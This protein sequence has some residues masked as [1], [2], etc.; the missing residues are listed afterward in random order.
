MLRLLVSKMSNYFEVCEIVAC[1]ATIGVL[2][3]QQVPII[4]ISSFFSAKY[5]I[6][7]AAYFFL[8]FVAF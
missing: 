4:S 7:G 5:Q 2:E 1:D 3:H 8:T 6:Y